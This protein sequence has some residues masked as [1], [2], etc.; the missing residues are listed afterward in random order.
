MGSAGFVLAINLF[1][2][3][4]IAVTFTT[5]AVHDP[6]RISARW[7]AL[8]YTI[9]MANPMTEFVIA[10]FGSSLLLVEIA[11]AVPLVALATLN[12]G[13][14]NKYAVRIPWVAMATVLLVSLAI[15]WGIQDMPRQS[16]MRM[17]LYQFPFFAMQA[18]AVGIIGQA[19]NRRGLDNLLMGLLAASSLHFL[20]KPFIFLAFGGTGATPADYLGTRYALLSQSM[21]TVFVVAIALA[22][23]VILV[24]DILLDAATRTETDPLSGLLNRGGFERYA[25]AAIDS[26]SRLGMPV[27]LV[28]SDLDRFKSINDT[29]GHASGD[30]V[31]AA[32]AEFLRS[33][34]T[35]HQLAGRIGGE[36]FAVLLPGTNMVAARLFA[37]GAR[38]AF[39]TASI[40]GL[41][42]T[43]RVTASFGVAEY[44]A[45]ESFSDLFARA[46]K[47]L[48]L[49]KESG[50][51][52]VKIAQRPDMRKMSD[53]LGTAV[54]I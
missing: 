46:D 35:E 10:T 48:Y 31:I 47:A 3:G 16:F 14:A 5:I 44:V 4:L 25:R 40:A 37:E 22:L 42:D 23:L 43:R 51:D 52:C 39:S 33:S 13:I 29:F 32:F 12:I 34:I 27:S 2:A 21:G 45:G 18:I 7:M 9:G 28:V 24:R 1:V 41:P 38:S 17:L 54:S 15:C 36:E 30:G 6:R 49:A 11:F 26:A 19:I 53:G 8:A 50:R 20:C